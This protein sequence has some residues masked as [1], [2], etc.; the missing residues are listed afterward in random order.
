MNAAC[1]V[2]F[3]LSESFLKLKIR[4]N[5]SLEFIPRGINECK[6]DHRNLCSYEQS[7]E[8]FRL[9]ERVEP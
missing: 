2:S 4:I 5:L 3:F 8:N 7:L 1:F 9:V 6:E